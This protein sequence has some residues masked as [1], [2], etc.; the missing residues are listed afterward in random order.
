[1]AMPPQLRRNAFG[2]DAAVKLACEIFARD[3]MGGRFAQANEFALFA[4]AAMRAG[5]KL[6]RVQS[7]FDAPAVS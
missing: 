6:H 1:M 4:R 5:E 3:W 7:R 2:V